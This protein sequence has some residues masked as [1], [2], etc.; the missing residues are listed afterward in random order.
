M[1]TLSFF[2]AAGEV[3]GS[4]YLW[5]TDQA[6]VLIDFGLHQGERD[7]V[8]LTHGRLDQC[9][10]LPQLTKAGFRGRIF[11]TR[12]TVEVTEI[13]LR[14]SAHLQEA[15]AEQDNRRRARQ[16]RP[17]LTPLYTVSDVE[18]TLPLLSALEYGVEQTVAPGITVRFF[19]AGH[20]LGSASVLMCAED[21]AGRAK[22]TIAF[23]GDVGVRN[24][25]ILRNP[26][27]PDHADTMVLESTYGDREHKP[28]G[29]TLDELVGILKLSQTEGGRIVIPSFA[30]GRPQDLIYHFGTLLREG[31]IP[32][33]NV[34]VDS[35][36]AI[37]ASG[38]YRRYTEVYD[39][40]SRDLLRRGDWPLSFPGLH[41]SRTSE[42]SRRLNDLAGGVVIISAAGMCTGGRILHH[43]R[44]SLWKPECRVVFV[45]YQGL[46]T[47]G[48]ER[49]D[50]AK[51]VRIFGETIAVK[52][53]V[54]TLNGFSAHAGQ[55]ELVQWAGALAPSKPRTFLTHGEDPPRRALAGRLQNEL[56]LRPELPQYADRVEL[57]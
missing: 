23:S 54:H 57:A 56:G 22:H 41:Y 12:P 42:E 20:I 55:S 43:L 36:M 5:P 28:M 19:D 6:S 47:L 26:M 3:T 38:L 37:A 35:P 1:I 33:L 11:C 53:R 52:A 18:Q 31:R 16:G 24:S 7:G 27:P 4:C 50:G 45:G 13:I 30:L 25:P 8:I 15:D 14:D 46:G 32:K 34:Y 49:V 21:R 10:R 9:G 44:H 17:P 40:A 39:E 2:G 29:P 51:T 48:R